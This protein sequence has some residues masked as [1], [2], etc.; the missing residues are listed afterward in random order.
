MPAAVLCARVL[1]KRTLLNSDNS[2]ET[3]RARETYG[4]R[5]M[6]IRS[7]SIGRTPKQPGGCSPIQ[8]IRLVALSNV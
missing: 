2:A 1:R 7:R 4:F 8:T 6:P 3:G 5:A